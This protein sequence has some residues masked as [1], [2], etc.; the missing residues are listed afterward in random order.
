MDGSRRSAAAFLALALGGI[1][2]HKFYLGRTAQGM[3]YLLLFWTF[4]PALFAVC[5]GLFYLSM[6][7]E[8]FERA[9]TGQ[10]SV[11]GL[12]LVDAITLI[13]VLTM[14]RD[15]LALP[16]TWKNAKAS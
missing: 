15:R 8:E 12:M 6:S 11:V 7:D 9:A 3:T 13:A 14:P 2:V 4:I 10:R 1:G 16:A 5:E